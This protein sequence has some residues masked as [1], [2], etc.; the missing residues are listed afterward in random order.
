MLVR[1]CVLVALAVAPIL[2]ELLDGLSDS[3]W[4]REIGI[5]SV[6][7]FVPGVR[8]TMWLSA[9]IIVLAGALAMWSLRA[10]SGVFVSGAEP[11]EEPSEA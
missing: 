1:F 10:G 5:G 9:I 4:D 7:V 6:E 11:R 2:S 8:L 3:L